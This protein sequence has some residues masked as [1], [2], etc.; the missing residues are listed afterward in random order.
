MSILF[1]PT[2]SGKEKLHV[3]IVTENVTF[4]VE[5]RVNL[6][7]KIEKKEVFIAAKWIREQ[8]KQTL[9]TANFSGSDA[10]SKYYHQFHYEIKQVSTKDKGIYKCVAN[11]YGY[12][13]VEAWYNLQVKGKCCN[14]IF[15]LQD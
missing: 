5:E 9:E 2:G 1:K 14:C 15:S 10:N 3:Y 12:G 11:F 4:V 13:P 7:C 8:T 6:V